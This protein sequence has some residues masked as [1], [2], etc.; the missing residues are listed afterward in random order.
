MTDNAIQ[1]RPKQEKKSSIARKETVA[2]EELLGKIFGTPTKQQEEIASRSISI[3]PSKQLPNHA[4]QASEKTQREHDVEDSETIAKL[5]KSGMSLEAAIR[6]V[7][8]Q[9]YETI[10]GQPQLEQSLIGELSHSQRLTN[11][12]NK[13]VQSCFDKDVDKSHQMPEEIFS[14]QAIGTF[15]INIRKIGKGESNRIKT[16]A[17]LDKENTAQK[18]PLY[19]SRGI[20]PVKKKKLN[21]FEFFEDVYGEIARTKSIYA[22]ELRKLDPALYMNIAATV[23]GGISSLLSTKSEKVTADILDL[24]A[25]KAIGARSTAAAYKR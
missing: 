2:K 24:V 3:N 15:A 13:W 8:P 7:R 18:P 19:K 10:E 5:V 20:D 1:E 9:L 22:H 12:I 16:M 23:T 4:K 11:R 21:P 14:T 17:W 6:K 25:S